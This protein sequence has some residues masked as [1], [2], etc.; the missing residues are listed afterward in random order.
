MILKLPILIFLEKSLQHVKPVD[1]KS[2]L[3]YF[4]CNGKKTIKSMWNSWIYVP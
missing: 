3:K 4:H 1:K 2:N